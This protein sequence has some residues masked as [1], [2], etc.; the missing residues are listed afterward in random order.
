MFEVEVYVLTHMTWS[1]SRW[2]CTQARKSLRKAG[3]TCCTAFLMTS[4]ADEMSFTKLS[5]CALKIRAAVLARK[6]GTWRAK[7]SSLYCRCMWH[8]GVD[9]ASALL[10]DLRSWSKVWCCAGDGV[11]QWIHGQCFC[12]SSLTRLCFECRRL[13][14]CLRIQQVLHLLQAPLELEPPYSAMPLPSCFVTTHT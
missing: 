2:H 1:L 7:Q 14:T 4:I 5:N 6:R 13:W 9:P 11:L 10:S 12:W 8:I 3:G